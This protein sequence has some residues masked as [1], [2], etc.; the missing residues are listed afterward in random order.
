MLSISKEI[1]S[2]IQKP[3]KIREIFEESKEIKK[4]YGNDGVCDF[5]L[6]N[7]VVNPPI[8]FLNALESTVKEDIVSKHGY[9]NHQGLLETRENVS[10]YLNN[11]YN[12]NVLSKHVVMTVGAAGAINVSLRSIINDDDEVILLT[13]Y[14]LEYDYYVHN[15]R[16]IVKYAQLDQDFDIN[17]EEISKVLSPKTR[18]IIINSPNNPTGKIF[19]TKKVKA[20][21]NLLNNHENEHKSK[22]YMIYDSPYEQLLYN[23]KFLNPFHV[24]DRTIYIGS[25]SKDFGIA[26]ER[27]GYIA[28]DSKV[29]DIDLLISA[30]VYNNRVLG[31]VNAPALMQRAISKMKSL[32]I[33]PEPYKKKKELIT[34]ILRKAGYSFVEPDGGIF[35]FPKSPIEDDIKFC[36]Y[37]ARNHQIFVVPGSSFGCKG[38]FRLSFSTSDSCILES[39]A[40]FTEA[41]ENFTKEIYV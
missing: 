4:V 34:S 3:S 8:E 28:I 35:L 15:C 37:L 19:S 38:Y 6:G 5:S 25:F 36:E 39:D 26:G 12:S 27:L 7:P 2:K 23:E 40:G 17:L 41:Y 30:C 31:F 33:N 10:D 18:A 20:L 1:Y 9:I 22:I 24:Y 14:F 11:R 16:G 13:P 32:I 21:S 29:E